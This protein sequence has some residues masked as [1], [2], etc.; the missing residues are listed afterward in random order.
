M[1]RK[2]ALRVRTKRGAKRGQKRNKKR[3]LFFTYTKAF[4]PIGMYLVIIHRSYL[5]A[6]QKGRSRV[7]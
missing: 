6:S 3:L 2:R 4:R 5:Y 1:G 7:L